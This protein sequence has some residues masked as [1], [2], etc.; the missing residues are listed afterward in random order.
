MVMC[1][2]SSLTVGWPG[3]RKF[4]TCALPSSSPISPSSMSS[5]SV[6]SL[7]RHRSHRSSHS[8]PCHIHVVFR[9]AHPL[10]VLRFQFAWNCRPRSLLL[11]LK[12]WAVALERDS[13]PLLSSIC[14]S[15]DCINLHGR[16]R[17][18]RSHAGWYPDE[19][20]KHVHIPFLSE[21]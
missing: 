15:I 1:S 9:R 5:S 4:L 13:S 20:I 11:P 6:S 7:T 18:W 16:V 10:A 17:D 2:W 19:Q 12:K 14:N 21:H 3:S 8:G